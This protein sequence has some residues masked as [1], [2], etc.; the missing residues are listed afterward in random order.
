MYK[1]VFL[2]FVV[3]SF[4]MTN[5]SLHA[6]R[7]GLKALKDKV[8]KVVP[9]KEEK[10][11]N[12]EEANVEEEIAGAS[13]SLDFDYKKNQL[14]YAQ[15]FFADDATIYQ[16]KWDRDY[17][18]FVGS[19][20]YDPKPKGAKSK[21]FGF[22]KNTMDKDADYIKD[23]KSPN[24][25]TADWGGLE[26]YYTNYDKGPSAW[27]R[28]SDK[29]RIEENH[30]EGK[31]YTAQDALDYG[32]GFMFFENIALF[33]SYKRYDKGTRY[34][35]D[36]V[37]TIYVTDK[38]AGKKLNPKDL[39]TR[40]EQYL[41]KG[42]NEGDGFIKGLSNQLAAEDRALNSIEGKEVKAIAVKTVGGE[43]KMPTNYIIPIEFV[44]TLAD[45]TTMSTAN[46]AYTSD[47]EIT[48]KGA[49]L[50]EK[51]GLIS[52]QTNKD[53][54]FDLSQVTDEVTVTIKSK[55]HPNIPAATLKL[56]FDYSQPKMH[57]LNYAGNPYID[58][59]GGASLVVEVKKV[60]NTVDGSNLL[61][62]R[63]RYKRDAEWFQVVRIKPENTL[64]LD[65]SGFSHQ[66]KSFD[67]NGRNGGDGGDIRLIVD[68][69]VTS[70]NFDYSNKGA[71]G[72]PAKSGGYYPGSP[73]RD[74]KF[75]K[76]T[77][78]VSF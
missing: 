15:E 58:Q 71:K 73:G 16:M 78:K 55:Y 44:A 30:G 37:E 20:V 6:Q 5:S 2:L 9:G 11:A 31:K 53:K 76:L 3:F 7:L 39:Q 4:A 66:S 72:Q 68:P 36:E 33:V 13:F 23:I 45:G 43:K 46:K 18:Q 17:N 14:V 59:W 67:G 34:V 28:W 38:K 47:Y 64:F 65:C 25:L 32:V 35:V 69:S 52:Y 56:P 51:G 40:I 57:T 60:K 61:E 74:G 8:Q 26:T 62:Y 70:Y 49:I 29:V 54:Y 27:V 22:G 42:E 48:V 21:L 10:E 12:V 63:L 41:V 75:E 50:D 1:K 24:S 19:E 77:Q